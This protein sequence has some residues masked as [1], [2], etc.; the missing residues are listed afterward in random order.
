MPTN[1]PSPDYEEEEDT[2]VYDEPEGGVPDYD[3]ENYV[4]E[5][6]RNTPVGEEQE[7][8]QEDEEL[9]MEGDGDVEAARERNA[10]VMADRMQDGEEED[11]AGFLGEDGDEE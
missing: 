7:A 10:E 3:N 2:P 1:D 5:D 6:W 9:D 8:P 11:V 4:T